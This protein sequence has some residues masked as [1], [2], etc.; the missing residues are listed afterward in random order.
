MSGPAVIGRA[1]LKSV[2]ESKPEVLE[3]NLKNLK[4]NFQA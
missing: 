4:S 2:R 1:G 3:V